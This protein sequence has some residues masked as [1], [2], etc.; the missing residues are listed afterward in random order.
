MLKLIILN[1]RVNM[2][3]L[4]DFYGV[5]KLFSWCIVFVWCLKSIVFF[6]EG[7][8]VFRDFSSNKVMYAFFLLMKSERESGCGG[9][10]VSL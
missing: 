8:D 10:C 4:Q 6:Y 5:L 7:D 2:L 9:I 3:L 1:P